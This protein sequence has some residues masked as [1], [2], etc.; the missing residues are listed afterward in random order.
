MEAANSSETLVLIYQ[1]KK[2]RIS[3]NSKYFPFPTRQ[4]FRMLQV[5]VL[6][7][8]LVC[9]KKFGQQICTKKRRCNLPIE[10]ITRRCSIVT[11]IPIGTVESRDERTIQQTDDVLPVYSE[12]NVRRSVMLRADFVSECHDVKVKSRRHMSTALLYTDSRHSLPDELL[13]QEMHVLT[14]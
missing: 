2:N 13:A 5:I 3:E 14:K 11:V 6:M 8:I 9:S 1:T 4:T 12:L 10:H 7:V